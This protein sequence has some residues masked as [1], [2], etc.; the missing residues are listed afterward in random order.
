VSDIGALVREGTDGQMPTQEVRGA[1]TGQGILP[2]YIVCDESGS[3]SGERLDS[4]N[5]ALPELHATIAADPLVS[6]KCRVGVIAFSD[7]AEVLLPLSKLSDVVEIPGLTAAT[8]TNYGAAFDLLARTIAQDIADLKGNQYRVFRPAVFFISDGEP[9]DYG[10]EQAYR[11]LTSPSVTFPHI[12]AYGVAGA[13]ADTIGKVG[14]KAAFI[15][16]PS[17]NISPAQ[18]LREILS[19]LTHTIVDSSSRAEPTLVIP[20]APDGTISVPMDEV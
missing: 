9:T 2:F 15:Q 17:K 14:T 19:S 10:W 18:A 3:M 13:N 5:A 7:S 12:I 1:S 6:D 8:V 16:D 11:N 20:P 4:V